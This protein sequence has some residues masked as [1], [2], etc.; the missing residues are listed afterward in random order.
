MLHLRPQ[1]ALNL[2]STD[3]IKY[4]REQ[5]DFSPYW[6]SAPPTSTAAGS[7]LFSTPPIALQI[8]IATP[9]SPALENGFSGIA[10]VDSD[11]EPIDYFNF[12]NQ[13]FFP[14]N[15]ATPPESVATLREPRAQLPTD[16]PRRHQPQRLLQLTSP[17]GSPFVPRLLST[18]EEG[19]FP[20]MAFESS[21]RETRRRSN[22]VPSSLTENPQVDI[23]IYFAYSD[24]LVKL[25]LDSG[26]T[27][28]ELIRAAARRTP[29]GWHALHAAPPGCNIGEIEH[30]DPSTLFKL[31][32]DSDW[33]NWL[34]RSLESGGRRLVL[35]AF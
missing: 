34:E 15:T 3:D 20:Y 4:L 18:P 6:M 14:Q 22:L 31:G 2:R 19:P 17:A 11:P 29:V 28:S 35:W 1:S 8:E 25:R 32:S 5:R 7:N 26:T 27:L 10:I 33:R 12:K 30:T 13:V 24:E 23:K 16:S 9:V 21:H